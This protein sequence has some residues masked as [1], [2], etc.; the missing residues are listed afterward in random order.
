M[1]KTLFSGILALMIGLN[2]N[3]QA[4]TTETNGKIGNMTIEAFNSVN[5]KGNQTVSAI[6]PTSTALSAA[7]KQLLT[8]IATGGQRQLAISQAVL[9]NVT[10]PQVK[11]LAT[12]EV[13][14]QT[15]IAAKLKEI[16]TAKGATLPEGPDAAAQ[17]L[18]TQAQ[19][20]KGAELDAFYLDQSGIKGH[21]LLQQTMTTVS[22]TAK[23]PTLKELA[24]GTL[25]VIRTHLSVSKS[26][27][28]MK[29][30]PAKSAMQ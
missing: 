29:K 23:D 20:L 22:T 25:P 26:I 7:D 27:K 28:S 24:V 21:E 4:D 9:A 1:K 5:A 12:S 14:E 2:A 18:V 13:E 11:L 30:S 10:N 15:G 19:N 16:A 3:A 6:T 17:Q 8:K